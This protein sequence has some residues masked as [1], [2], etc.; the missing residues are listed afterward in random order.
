V[1]ITGS[2]HVAAMERIG[3]ENLSGLGLDPVS[4]VHLAAD[5]GCGHVSLNLSHPANRLSDRPDFCLRE[6][7][8]LRRATGK[9]LSDRGVR[10]SLME[11]LV[12]QPGGIAD[13]TC[14]LDLAAELGARAVCAISLER[15]QPKAHADFRAL[16]EQAAPLGI[17]VTTEVGA[18]S[19][20]NWDRAVAAIEAVAHPAFRL[21]IDTMHY[22]RLGATLT[23]L[24]EVEPGIVGHI[25]LCD[26][27]MP[28]VI[29]S[30]ME[31]ALYE[32]RC[33][34]DGDLPLREFLGLISPEVPVG[35]EIP[36]RSEAERGVSDHDRLGR[37]VSATRNL[38][39]PTRTRSSG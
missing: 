10:L 25:Q 21:L 22:F 34:G 23:D 5:L 6:D 2:F 33:P 16:A 14:D 4:L 19:I 13:F 36:I 38:L 1:E 30:Y 35:L 20:R 29:G 27:P 37:C 32:R 15:D 3:I 12:I 26:V 17:I 11:G 39:T 18:G 24:A 9:A 31:E 7:A 28:A 8:T